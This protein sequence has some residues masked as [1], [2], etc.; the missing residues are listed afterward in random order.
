MNDDIYNELCIIFSLECVSN[1]H[2]ENETNNN[3]I[4]YNLEKDSSLENRNGS[5]DRNINTVLP[6]KHPNLKSKAASSNNTKDDNSSY[7]SN[8]SFSNEHYQKTKINL[9]PKIDVHPNNQ[10]YVL[11]E[12]QQ[13]LDNV[14]RS[15][16]ERYSN[17]LTNLPQFTNTTNRYNSCSSM[18]EQFL[19]AF[20]MT[21]ET[22]ESFLLKFLR[23]GNNKFET[24]TKILINYILLMRDHPKYY[25]SSLKPDVIQKVYDEKIHTVLPVRDKFQ[26]RVFIW[27]PGK[28]NPETISFTDCYCA[29]YMLCEMMA[30]E[31]MTQIEGC[32]V[33][34]EGSNIGFRQ[35]RSMCLEDI[36]NSANFIQVIYVW[37]SNSL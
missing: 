17:L 7:L 19:A 21:S 26:R 36:K 18:D 5:V 30:L 16:Q 37:F 12:F 6:A 10:A 9:E 3:L 25:S 23:A 13:Y 34:C 22:S 8:D 15:D 33:V 2:Q 24:A 14:I 29:M 20:P 11:N 1:Y 27:R 4:Y 32:T 35:L 28:W 31:P